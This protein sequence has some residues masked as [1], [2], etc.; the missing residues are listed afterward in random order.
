MIHGGKKHGMLPPD[1]MIAMLHDYIPSLP[2]MTFSPDAS[3]ILSTGGKTATNYFALLYCLWRGNTWENRERADVYGDNM[4]RDA[5]CSQSQ[6]DIHPIPWSRSKTMRVWTVDKPDGIIEDRISAKLPFRPIIKEPLKNDKPDYQR[7]EQIADASAELWC[8]G[9]EH[10]NFP[11]TEITARTNRRI[12][13]ARTGRNLLYECSPEEALAQLPAIARED[14]L[15]AEFYLSRF[16]LPK[17][18][19]YEDYI[20]RNGFA[21]KNWFDEPVRG[22]YERAVIHDA[23]LGKKIM[24]GRKFEPKTD[25]TAANIVIEND[26]RRRFIDNGVALYEAVT[27]YH[28][29]AYRDCDPKYPLSMEE[30]AKRMGEGVPDAFIHMFHRV[31]RSFGGRLFA[32]LPQWLPTVMERYDGYVEGLL[33]FGKLVEPEFHTPKYHRMID[34]EKKRVEFAALI[35]AGSL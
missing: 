27:S 3:G 23:R 14:D 10:D 9:Q 5:S 18:M 7:V 28:R 26:G 1:P 4:M 24:R 30:R 17:R 15:L 31:P 20:L 29:Q 16:G 12:L 8:Y 11:L 22:E 35:G 34:F 13:A 21:I 25:S 2:V 33:A 6:R 19:D 32:P